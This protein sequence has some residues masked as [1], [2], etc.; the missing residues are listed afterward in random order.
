MHEILLQPG[1]AIE[2]DGVRVRA[3]TDSAADQSDLIRKLRAIRE[4]AAR[5]REDNQRA[6]YSISPGSIR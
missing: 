5:A 6:L 1:T 3:A 4:E 2:I